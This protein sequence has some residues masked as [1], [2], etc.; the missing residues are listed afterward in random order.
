MLDTFYSLGKPFI[1]S[2]VMGAV[3]FV[4]REFIDSVNLMKFGLLV[5]AGMFSYGTTLYILTGRVL[6]EDVKKT[7]SSIFSRS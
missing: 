6:F 5:L 2:F 4:V 1:A 7:I 3:L